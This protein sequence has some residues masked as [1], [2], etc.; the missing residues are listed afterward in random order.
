MP[1]NIIW[2]VNEQ[3]TG[4]D[5][6]AGVE[7]PF[8]VLG[9]AELGLPEDALKTKTKFSS[10]PASGLSIKKVTECA[11]TLCTRTYNMSVS[12]GVVVKNVSKP[13]YGKFIGIPDAGLGW[14]KQHGSP[15]NLTMILGNNYRNYKHSNVTASSPLDNLYFHF[16][17]LLTGVH[18][19]AWLYN[20][21]TSLKLTKSPPSDTIRRM[22]TNGLE[23]AVGNIANSLTKLALTQSNQN[24]TGTLSQT[25]TI[26]SVKW[27]WIILPAAVVLFSIIFLITTILACSRQKQLA[28]WKSSALPLLYHGL[29]DGVLRNGENH[30]TVSGMEMEAKSV[31][32]KL[33]ESDT[34]RGL[35]FR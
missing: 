12:G 30:V 25:V 6:Y 31:N 23:D 1:N 16:E 2:R 21:S 29:D 13:N 27:Q 22:L 7:N 28:L 14:R 24:V 3:P 5:V 35:R 9:H 32:V 18:N 33:E 15:V 8:F 17:N 20:S 26:V 4:Q 11:L 19:Y 34:T 10:Y